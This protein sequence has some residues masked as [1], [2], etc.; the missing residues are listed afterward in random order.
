MKRVL[1]IVLCAVVTWTAQAQT[2]ATYD[3]L[4]KEYTLLPDGSIEYRCH[5]ELTLHT[6][7][8]FNQL[9]GETF[10]VF[11]PAW[12]Q[13]S[14]QESYTRQADG[15]VVKTPSNAFNEVLPA[16]AKDAPFYNGLREL[17]I[18]HTGLEMGATIVLDYTV[19]TK[20]G[21]WPALEVD[22]TLCQTGADMKE[23]RITVKVPQGTELRWSLEGRRESPVVTGGTYVWTFRGVPAASG[24]LYAPKYGKPRLFATTLPSTADAMRALTP[25]QTRD[26]CLPPASVLEGL[27][28][29]TDKAFA[30]QQY[31]AEGLGACGV[32]PE[33]AGYCARTVNDVMQTAYGTEMEKSF[34]LAK[35]LSCAGIPAEV[36]AVY[37][38]NC[39]V[40][41]LKNIVRLLV[42]ADADGRAYYLS[43]VDYPSADVRL[44]ADREAVV[45][46]AGE[47][48]AIDP[49]TVKIA[50]EAKITVDS[51]WNAVTE[52]QVRVPGLLYTPQEYRSAYTGAI[53]RRAGSLEK[54]EDRRIVTDDNGQRVEFRAVRTIR[55]QVGYALLS[56][57]ASGKGPE[58]WAMTLLNTSRT[59]AV[60]IPYAVQEE[61]AYEIELT[62]GVVSATRDAEVSIDNAAGSLRISVKN[63]PG[64]IVVHRAISLPKTQLSVKDYE[65]LR[66]I[67]LAWW[68]ASG[69]QV[70]LKK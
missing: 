49:E 60:E 16:A 15:T 63:E 33:M 22:E 24:D 7:T 45:N 66:E 57:P 42:K 52:A 69:Q 30:I 11:D 4:E 27:E 41:G 53:V 31:V 8:A 70:I 68:N 32:T 35:M 23:C 1:W 61:D 58:S 44:R 48:I 13:V 46:L 59:D 28:S 21:F 40:R 3:R 67:L 10:I 47:E 37:P 51:S 19:R 62:G 20:P 65:A 2:E 17:V 38:K 6:Q 39:C 25:P 18:T 56:L 64:R 9:F 50:Y 54:E 5:K 14:I 36:V 26:I 55:P 12:Q 34:V 29:Q 43:A